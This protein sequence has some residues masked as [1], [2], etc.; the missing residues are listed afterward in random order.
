MTSVVKRLAVAGVFGVISALPV[1]AQDFVPYGNVP[2]WDIVL[3]PVAGNGCVAIASFVD[4]SDV[5]LGVNGNDGSF[6]LLAMNAGWGDIE[7]GAIEAVTISVDDN[8]YEGE[9]TSMYIGD[10][11]AVE[12]IFETYDYLMDIAAGSTLTLTDADGVSV[13]YDLAGAPAAMAILGQCMQEMGA[14]E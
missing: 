9:M 4:G 1:M 10:L 8:V 2:G 6:Y 13:A 5:R 11:P 3:D 14:S 12:I 7:D